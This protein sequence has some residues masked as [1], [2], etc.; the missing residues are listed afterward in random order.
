MKELGGYLE[1]ELGNRNSEYHRG[2]VRLNTGRNALE[3]ILRA[4]NYKKLYL[5]HYHCSALITPLERLGL[6]YELYHIDYNF[7][8]SDIVV[9]ADEAILYINFFGLK[10]DYI[11]TLVGKY[12]NLIVD[13]AHSFFSPVHS[14]VDTFYSCRKFFGVPDGAYV[15]ATKHPVMDVQEDTSYARYEHLVGRR[16]EGATAH[17]GFYKH[18]ENE[19]ANEPVKLMS[20]STQQV[21]EN[22]DYD[23]AK[24]R[25]SANYAHLHKALGNRNRLTLPSES[26]GMSYPLLAS[27]EML[28]KLIE[29]KVYIGVYWPNVIRDM[30]NDTVEHDLALNLL[31]LPIDQRYDIADMDEIIKRIEK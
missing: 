15:A 10:D 9:G 20:R 23:S 11:A 14:G 17:Y 3:Y 25:R 12:P 31:S 19:F 4:H 27:I 16:D 22:I 29:Q 30:P 26:M 28:H 18:I 1:L 7:E 6:P 2:L 21:M 5:P 8:F 24:A 13:N